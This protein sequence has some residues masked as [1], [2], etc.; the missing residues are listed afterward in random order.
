MKSKRHITAQN[1]QRW[2][3][4][5]A[6]EAARIMNEEMI[7]D[8][9]QAKLKASERLGC[10]DRAAMPS[11]K[12]VQVAL[13]TYIA[14]FK[15]DTQPKLLK[16]LRQTA[17][18]AMDFLQDFS[19]RL[20]GSVLNGT[21]DEEAAVHLHVFAETEEEVLQFLMA[22]SIPYE[23]EQRN[24]NYSSKLAG[25]VLLCRFVAD[26]VAIELSVFPVKGLRQAPLSPVDG[27]P[28]Q[29]A[30]RKDIEGLL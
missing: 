1:Q 7:R 6:Q 9:H 14:L 10:F 8:Y 26:D 27:K 13:Q 28:M 12:E 23:I 2:R 24:V 18:H 22:E 30:T 4:S 25:E 19:P 15:S 3:D 20:V 17:L 29:R 21:C 11:N 5:I 16:K